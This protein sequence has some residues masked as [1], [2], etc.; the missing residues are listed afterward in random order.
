MHFKK[1]RKIVI[2]LML[3]LSTRLLT[4]CQ[5]TTEEVIVT[6]KESNDTSSYE[7]T[8]KKETNSFLRNQINAPKHY[9]NEISY[10][11]GALKI[12]TDAE[13]IVPEVDSVDTIS[14]SAKE[15]D[16]E[17]IDKT[18]KAFFGNNPVYDGGRY[19]T[20]TKFQIEKQIDTLE[21]YAAEGNMY[22]Y[23]FMPEDDVNAVMKI[24]NNFLKTAPENIEKIK[25]NPQ[26]GLPANYEDM[27]GNQQQVTMANDFSGVVETEKGIYDYS[28]QRV[29][30]SVISSIVDITKKS[31]KDDLYMASGWFN[32]EGLL[33]SDGYI[34]EKD[35]AEK[36]Y[37]NRRMLGYNFSMNEEEI[38]KYIN[39]SYEDAKALADD[40]IEALGYDDMEVNASGYSL[41]YTNTIAKENIIEGAYKFY[42][43]RKINNFPVSYTTNW[44]GASEGD[45]VPWGYEVIN[46][47]VGDNGIEEVVIR[48]PYDVGAVIKE[49]V[50]L[51]SFEEIIKIYE[52]MM[53]N[54][55]F[56][57]RE[58]DMARQREFAIA[59][60][61]QRTY[62]IT[63]IKL[64]Y[65]RIYD[66]KVDNKTGVLVPV[67][68]FYGG[69]DID[70]KDGDGIRNNGKYT[71]DSVITIN[72]VDGTIIDRSLGY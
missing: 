43:T 45:I 14:V 2:I 17:L 60:I 63:K 51:L 68:D 42:Y 26:F 64:G 57:I 32:T 39:I 62:H 56:D 41:K 18:T 65:C 69:F 13:V 23:A 44:G 34:R 8:E 40:K 49:N 50:K 25:V 7:A 53:E 47:I 52:Q 24:Y 59:N 37:M 38:K 35:Q 61:E 9:K 15:F 4:A 27:D 71:N 55:D 10:Q 19:N 48:D 36:Y 54:A 30:D 58:L 28:M 16:Q 1:K 21:K 22:P 3:C 29:N 67:W 5:K 11:N 33:S 20:L 72:A 12:S 31:E 66:P 70:L 6:E 46:F